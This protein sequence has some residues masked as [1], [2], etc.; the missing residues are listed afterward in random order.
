MFDYGPGSKY[1]LN[2]PLIVYHA[3]L[4][5]AELLTIQVAVEC[6]NGKSDLLLYDGDYFGDESMVISKARKIT[7][8]ALTHVDMFCLRN[9]DLE[10]AFM[11]YPEERKRVEEN[12]GLE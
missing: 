5:L 6:S 7:T 4:H 11:S 2:T 1:V 10:E 3:M 8:R 9:S 12:L